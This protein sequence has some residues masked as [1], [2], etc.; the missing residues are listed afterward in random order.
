[1]L[2]HNR[3]EGEWKAIEKD[4]VPRVLEFCRQRAPITV[5]I[6]HP[7][8]DEEQYLVN[9]IRQNL[10]KR[11]EIQE[12]HE[13]GMQKILESQLFLFIATEH[14]I[15][16]EQCQHELELAVIHD[17]PIIPIKVT[18]IK[19]EDLSK[20]DLGA[21]FNMSEKLGFEL[22]FNSEVGK[23]KEFHDKL[24]EYIKKYKC[25][26]NLFEPEERK[27]DEQWRNFKFIGEK[28]VQSEKFRE[29]LIENIEQFK[30]LSEELKTKKISLVEYLF[31]W[32]QILNSKSK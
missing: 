18:E 10:K 17:I 5:F 7:R 24:Y 25:E 32:G 12:V 16:N 29:K 8:K 9:D 14:S 2:K 22:E 23:E 1:L 19:W 6:N 21:K 20:I 13:S 11:E 26:V 4:T 30:N 28:L 3:W 15:N 27:V 31:K